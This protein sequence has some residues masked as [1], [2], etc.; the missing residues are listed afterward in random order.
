MVASYANNVIVVASYAK[1]GHRLCEETDLRMQ[2][3]RPAGNH[4]MR[5]G[6]YMSSP[7]RRA[8]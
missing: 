3:R 2:S 7:W 4:E 5:L 8:G 1:S 6:Q